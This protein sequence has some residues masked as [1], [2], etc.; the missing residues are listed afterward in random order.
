MGHGQEMHKK[1]NRIRKATAWVGSLF[2]L[3]VAGT[4]IVVLYFASSIPSLS[5]I[6]NR[7]V[8]QSTKIFDRDSK[9]LLY[10]ISAGQKRTVVPLTEIPSRLAEATVAVEDE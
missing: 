6:E 7:Q 10:E 9:T 4:V 2:L 3:V 8:P 1:R 5:Q